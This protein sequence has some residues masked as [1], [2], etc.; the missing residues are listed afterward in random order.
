MRR[1]LCA[2]V[3][4]AVLATLIL[5]GRRARAL[6]G[7]Q[8]LATTQAAEGDQAIA[9]YRRLLA[10]RPAADNH[11]ALAWVLSRYKSANDDA[12]R[13]ATQALKLDPNQYKAH[14]I[15]AIILEMQRRDGD[16]LDHLL[17]MMDQDRPETQYYISRIG[18]LNVTVTQRRKAIA[19]L[20]RFVAGPGRPIHRATARWALARLL[21]ADGKAEEARAAYDRLGFIKTWRVIGPFDNE[22]NAG[23]GLVQGPEK[24]I[25]LTK[26]YQ[27]RGVRVS[28]R[29]LEHFT[30]AGLCDLLAVMYPNDQVLGYA[31]T[32]VQAPART[33][34]VVRLGAEQSV[35][36]WLNDRLIVQD[37]QNKGFA[38]DQHVAPVI[39]EAGWNK[40]L[41]KV[42]RRGGSWRFALRL[43]DPAGNL[44]KSLTSSDEVQ[45][46]PDASKSP[47]PGFEYA[48]GMLEHFN[49]QVAENR[50]NESAVYYLSQAQSAAHRRTLATQTCEWLVSLNRH[51]SEYRM[52]VALAYWADEKPDKAFEQLKAAREL[53]PKNLLAL[54]LLGRFYR[55]RDALEQAREILDDAAAVAPD[56]M[57]AHLGLQKVYQA[58]G[59]THQAYA[60]AKMLHGRYPDLASL[61]AN[62]AAFCDGYGYRDQAR[63]LWAQAATQNAADPK[64]HQALIR[65]STREDRVEDALARCKAYQQL[66]PMSHAIRMQRVGLLL[67]RERYD[68][69]IAL[70]KEAL[71]ICP[72][73]AGFHAKLGE[74]HERAGRMAEAMTAWRAAL[75]YKPDDRRL[76]DY[77]EF[78]Q[79]EQ[80][81]PVFAKFG[82][83]PDEAARIVKETPADEATY[84]KAVAVILLDHRVTE[85]FEDG[86]T[87]SQEH[88]ICKI[89]NERGRRKYTKVPLRGQNRKVLRAAVIKPDGTEVEATRVSGEAIHFAQ[90]QPGSI[91]EYKVIYYRSGTSWLSRHYTDLAAFQS[92]DPVVRRQWILVAT[93]ARSVRH[94]VRGDHVK[95]T[96]GEF[97]GKRV[98]AFRA[99]NVPMLETEVA[100]PPQADILEQIRVSTIED[101]DE[102]ARWEWA[103]IKDQ[104]A[105]D[106]AIR[107]KVKALTG[108]CKTRADR[109][110]AIY[111][112]VAQKIQYKVMHRAG[113]FGIKPDKAANV[114]A[115]EWG[116][117]KGKAVLLIAMLREAGIKACY[118]T[119]RTRS[120]GRLLEELPSNQ[121][122]HA[123]VYVPEPDNFDRGLWLD[124]TAEYNG[125]DALPWGDRGVSA[126]VWKPN[127]QMVFKT[128]P[129]VSPKDNTVNF[130]LEATLSKDGSAQARVNWQASGQFAAGFRQ[131]FRRVGRRQ[132]QLEAVVTSLQ[133]GG[134]LS[135]M[136]FSDL[137]DRDGP[138]EI[139]FDFKASQ[140]AEPAG[141]HLVLSSKRK[142]NLTQ[143]YTPRT[144]RHYD[145][146]LSMPSTIEYS[147]VYRFKP[148]WKVKSA[149]PSAR[150]TTPWMD[151]EIRYEAEPGR[152]R[153][154]KR[155]V[156]KATDV[157]RAEYGRL[158]QFCIDADEHEQKTIMLEP[159]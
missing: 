73:H 152:L 129:Q 50:Q 32:F 40:I 124:A 71:A 64:A 139:R 144:E 116:E 130:V 100:R 16:V 91:L 69:A 136:A 19:A 54:S 93:K 112:F 45:R 5:G 90:L 65:L 142:F 89:L 8:A 125:M 137:T 110:R 52:R 104:F 74:I 108:D 147:E 77:L 157:P 11:A 17:A 113:I 83:G 78:L 2:I 14:E 72:S 43:T 6:A 87:T 13:H 96:P 132:Q 158:R 85:L 138:A 38:L 53:E 12:L 86:S 76:R 51:C 30:L 117:C 82:V 81:N 41:V 36:V 102:I 155:L 150:V 107:E 46:T 7:P 31:V 156:I 92:T 105:S 133:P 120:A 109:M 42:C 44:L 118:A 106:T 95:L 119:V 123:I 25:D 84:P 127:G 18:K 122:N 49:R 146:W 135:D 148:T 68:D 58:R 34:A 121:C 61:T 23:F 28:W 159:Q 115:N 153:V 24:E 145:V 1:G 21:L 55:S 22:A 70:C 66:V 59:W 29:K 154:D 75:R 60:K 20:K 101:W 37:D 47:A 99:D 151:Y 103:L 63:T 88:G 111:N 134:R 56:S 140:Y 62:Y 80:E 131:Q 57:T 79:P 143:R 97:E 141:P 26:R 67:R 48:E 149:P 15:A 114:L 10:E 126:L 94:V 33:E 128:V 9:R 39:L 4:L 35:K 3:V 27:G 98:Y